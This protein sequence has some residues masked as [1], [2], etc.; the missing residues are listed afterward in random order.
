MKAIPGIC[1][2]CGLR[3]RLKSLK[4]EYILGKGTGNRVCPR[5]YDKSHPQLDTRNVK[6]NDKQSVKDSRSDKAELA[7]SR[8]M[9][10]FNSIEN[11]FRDDFRR[12]SGDLEDSP[13]WTLMDGLAGGATFTTYADGTALASNSAGTDTVYGAPDIDTDEMYVQAKWL[14]E[15]QPSDFINSRIVARPVSAQL[16]L[17]LGF[18]ENLNL[19]L[20]TGYGTTFGSYAVTPTVGDVIRLE[21]S[22]GSSPTASQVRALLNGVEVIPWTAAEADVANRG[23]TR[24]GV[25]LRS[26]SDPWI[27]EFEAGP[28]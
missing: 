1:D 2:R 11:I 16:T 22:N 23:V 3:F 9:Y 25:E 17:G 7:A 4:E 27:T 21:V 20:L 13:F 12:Y 19:L 8:L 26:T 10:G 5:C 24:A 18:N 15:S 28:L 14:G 6:T